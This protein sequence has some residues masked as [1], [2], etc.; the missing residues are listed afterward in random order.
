[1]GG[2]VAASSASLVAFQN[3]AN[4]HF[5]RLASAD[6]Q[7]TTVG[8]VAYNTSGNLTV[9]SVIDGGSF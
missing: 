3:T 7:A 2:A 9:S 8:V 1:M 6:S 4:N 5:G